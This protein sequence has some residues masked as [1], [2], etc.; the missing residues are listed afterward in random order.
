MFPPTSGTA[1][2]VGH[3]IVTDIAGVRASIGICPQHDVLFAELTV[4]EHIYFYVKLKGL[5]GKALSEEVD[6]YVSLLALDSK[7]FTLNMRLSYYKLIMV[8]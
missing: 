3:D 4:A 6:K 8:D 2:V 1:T 7:V 5:S